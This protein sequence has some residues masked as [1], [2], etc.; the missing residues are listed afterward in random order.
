MPPEPADRGDGRR[1]DHRH[2]GMG[3][4]SNHELA[5]R[6]TYFVLRRNRLLDFAVPMPEI[7]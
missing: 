6:P 5:I 1:K 2:E 3:G 4:S 7:A